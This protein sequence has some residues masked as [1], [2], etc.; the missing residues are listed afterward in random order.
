MI[1][2]LFTSQSNHHSKSSNYATTHSY[3]DVMDSIPYSVYYVTIE[4]SLIFQ[5]QLSI[6]YCFSLPLSVINFF[7][8]CW[9]DVA[10][11][12]PT[13]M[14]R[15]SVPTLFWSRLNTQCFL[16]V[17]VLEFKRLNY[18]DQSCPSGQPWTLCIS[19]PLLISFP[20]CIV[21]F[22]LLIFFK[23]QL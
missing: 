4:F 11:E 9:K 20:F 17:W 15:D 5:T 10:F 21:W 6:V 13:F 14:W 22:Y 12:S 23:S 19:S 16:L 3:Y 2:H 1:Q 8:I 7:C 18:Q